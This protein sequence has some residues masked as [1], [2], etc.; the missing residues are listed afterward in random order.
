MSLS[1]VRSQIDAIDG[2]IVRLLAA[3]QV[4]VKQAAAYKG[5]G[6]AVRAPDRRAAMMTRL[7][8]LA[9]TEG[10]A[11]EVVE[12]VYTEMIDAFIDLELSEHARIGRP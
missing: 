5:D 8:E 4:L 1:E 11:P 12:R 2:R 10:V 3:R 9:V 6:D 7:R